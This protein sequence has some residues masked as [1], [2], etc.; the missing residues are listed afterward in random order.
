MPRAGSTH[1]YHLFV[2]RSAARDALKSH[3]EE[4]AIQTLVHYPLPV[5]EQPAYRGR[6]R[7]YDHLPQTERAAKEILS[8]PMYPELPSAEI[9]RVIQAINTF[10]S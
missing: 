3:L 6:L 5:H 2:V 7:G 4:H 8:L 10:H 9:T 1:V